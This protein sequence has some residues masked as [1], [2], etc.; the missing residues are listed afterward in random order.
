MADKLMV[1]D[2]LG[3]F[4]WVMVNLGAESLQYIPK[5]QNEKTGRTVSQ[6][7]GASREESEQTCR[8]CPLWKEN[9][10]YAQDGSPQMG[11]SSVLRVVRNGEDRSIEHALIH[12]HKTAKYARFGSIGDP[13]SIAPEVYQDHEQQTRGAGLGVISYTHQWYLPH[14]QF[15]KGHAL[16]SADNMKDVVD[17]VAAGWRSAVHVDPDAPLFDG[18]SIAEKPQGVMNNGIKYFLCPAQRTEN[19]VTCNDCGL[20]DG[21][22]PM[23]YNTI[24]FVEHGNMML[25]KKQRERRA[26]EALAAQAITETKA[27]YPETTVLEIP[28]VEPE[29]VPV[30]LTLIVPEPLPEPDMSEFTSR[31]KG[32]IFPR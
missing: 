13:G 24:V 22:K 4:Q 18:K 14:A 31:L 8:I 11:H 19:K 12:K 20:C 30:V 29:P 25:W 1:R 15:L 9:T 5:S 2:R 3:K 27:L 7:I 17:S 21:T 6:F 10:C 26:A 16:A 28:V 23:K 32:S